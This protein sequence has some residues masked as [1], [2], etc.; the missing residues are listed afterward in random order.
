[1]PRRFCM[2]KGAKVNCK[3]KQMR[4]DCSKSL[5]LEMALS[6]VTYSL[7]L[8]TYRFLNALI[9]GLLYTNTVICMSL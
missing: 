4:K 3:L 8:N 9:V 6:C 2:K 5:G 1:M 7:L